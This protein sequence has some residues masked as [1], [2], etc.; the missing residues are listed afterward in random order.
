MR[1]RYAQF[2]SALAAIAG[3]CVMVGAGESSVESQAG[4]P[5][6]HRVVFIQPAGFSPSAGQ[7]LKLSLVD[8]SSVPSTLLKPTAEIRRFLLRSTGAQENRETLASTIE[9][10]TV[11]ITPAIPRGSALV[12]IELVPRSGTLDITLFRYFLSAGASN[13]LSP[14]IGVREVSVSQFNSCKAI[15]HGSNNGSGSTAVCTKTGLRSEICPLTDPSVI[16]IGSDLPVRAMVGGSPAKQVR[17][18][19][20]PPGSDDPR[21]LTTD[22]V[23]AAHV[24]IDA[25]GV[26]QLQFQVARPAAPGSDVEWD[27]FTS[28]LV[29]EVQSAEG[30]K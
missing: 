6:V 10:S 4:A 22:D 3:S 13:G 9:D 12:G 11:L 30:A 1:N 2:G 5:Y 21:A 15:V 7:P 17:L 29:F 18:V 23:G 28:T 16:P 20:T 24:R 19:V 14:P 25:P 8:R 27:I 26:W